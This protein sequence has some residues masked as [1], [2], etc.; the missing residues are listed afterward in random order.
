MQGGHRKHH[1][2]V[3]PAGRDSHAGLVHPPVPGSR[4]ATGEG[5][6]PGGGWGLGKLPTWRS[7]EKPLYFLATCH[8]PLSLSL[9]ICKMGEIMTLPW[10][11]E[12]ASGT[13]CGAARFQWLSPASA[14]RAVPGPQMGILGPEREGSPWPPPPPLSGEVSDPFP[15]VALRPEPS[16]MGLCFKLGTTGR[17]KGSSPGEGYSDSRLHGMGGQGM[18]SYNTPNAAS[19]EE[20]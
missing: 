1:S 18:P 20:L 16:F 3:G 7:P 5:T 2:R 10:R 8:C 12:K 11:M 6:N 13:L 4:G 14:G 19:S 15:S 9:P 17:R